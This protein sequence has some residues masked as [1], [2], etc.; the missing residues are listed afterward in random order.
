MSLAERDGVG[1]VGPLLVY[2]NGTVQHAGVVLASAARPTT[3]CAASRATPTATRAR[4]LHARGLRRD[5]RVHARPPRPLPR[6]RRV[7]RALRDALP[8]R[9]PLPPHRALGPAHPLHAAGGARPPRERDAGRPSTTTSTARFSSTRG[10]RRSRAATRTTTRCSRSTAPTTDPRR[11]RERPLR[12]LPRLHEQQ[13]GPH[14]QPRER[15][16]RPASA[17]PS[18]SR[19]TRTRSRDR[20]A[21]LPDPRLP[22]RA[23]RRLGFPDGGPPTLVHAL[24]AAR[25]RA[26]AHRGARRAAPL[27]VRRPP[28]GQRGCDHRRQPRHD[29]STSCARPRR[30]SSTRRPLAALAPGADAALPRR[31]RR[32]DGDHRPAAR[33]PA[34]RRPGRDRLA[35]VRAGALHR[36]PAGA[37]APPPARNRRRASR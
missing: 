35:G 14:L 7:R 22:R 11:P 19:A 12:Q 20:R 2:P 9:R 26:R 28:R 37:G 23:A 32:D 33:V 3:S 24:D 21:A 34:R 10:A 8:G 17:A 13:R 25:G 4:S 6:A 1:A 15:A 18:R 5:R 27:P 30:P 36:R 16:L 31:R 29:A